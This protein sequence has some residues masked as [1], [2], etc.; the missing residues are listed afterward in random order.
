MRWDQSRHEPGHGR[1]RLQ[2]EPMKEPL[3]AP[4]G[5]VRG[6]GVARVIIVLSLGVFSSADILTPSRSSWDPDDQRTGRPGSSRWDIQSPA[7]SRDSGIGTREYALVLLS[8]TVCGI[9]FCLTSKFSPSLPP[10]VFPSPSL[11]SFSLPPPLRS[12]SV[13]LYPRLL[14]NT[15]RG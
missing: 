6:S 5:L 14:T 11:L 9:V 4:G 8:F 13:L 7:L 1:K 2:P 10:S 15:T 12:L 3:P